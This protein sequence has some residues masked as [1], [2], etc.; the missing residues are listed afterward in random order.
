MKITSHHVHKSIIH[1]AYKVII[2]KEILNRINV[3]PVRDGDTGSNLAS[4]MQAIIHQSEEKHSVKD[5]LQSIADA[6]LVGARGNSG[7]IFAQYLSGLCESMDE[8]NKITIEQFAKASQGAVAYAYEA[9]EKPLEGTI[10]SHM[11]EWGKIIAR[12]SSRGSSIEEIF[13]KAFK[14]LE[15]A[16]EKTKEQMAILKESDVVDSG[17]KG[18]TYFVEGITH[19]IKNGE[20]Q[21]L[22]NIQ[23]ADK[24]RVRLST[25]FQESLH[26]GDMTNRYCTECLIGD[27]N[28]SKDVLKAELKHYGTS[29]VVAG[30]KQKY[31]IHIHTDE[32]T[33]VFDYLH[34]K[35][36][37]LF[38]KVDDMKKQE[39]IVNSQK[40]R[41]ALVTDSIADL[42]QSFIDDHQ[43]HIVHLN[44]L[45]EDQVYIDRLT[46]KPFRLL[47]LSKN[48]KS[49]P[50]SSQPN[51]QQIRNLYGYLSTYYDGAIVLTVSK[52]L[53]GTYSNLKQTA[54]TMNSSLKLAIV[55]TKQNSGAEGLLVQKC[56]QRIEEGKDMD[57]IVKEME[58]LADSCKILVQVKRLEPMIKSGRLNVH[59]G[60]IIGKIGVKPIISLDHDGKGA[61]DSIAFSDKESTNKI[62]RHVKKLLKK[63]QIESYNIVH[64]N[65]LKEAHKLAKLMTEIIGFQPA[66]IEET[67][68][69]VAVSAGDKAIALSYLL[70]KEV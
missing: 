11:K 15:K 10:I 27:V 34:L 64:V 12:E 45:Y 55:N 42:P 70:K 3:F 1:G 37:V 65:N 30:S 60:N 19:Y 20:S 54:K 53:S 46:I 9:I 7:I 40:S 66:Y 48:N 52:E 56:A 32:P 13:Y 67:S 4:M 26:Q 17:A 8:G 44:I 21:D 16:L 29:L 28:E 39:A 51:T 38:Q 36:K 57:T 49:L 33:K 41:I 63:S 6:A 2:N 18:F 23:E 24:N 62:I 50:T 5:T 47:E 25:S 14:E 22:L 31:R 68:S 58:T 43:I 35:G 69:I 61:I 59:I